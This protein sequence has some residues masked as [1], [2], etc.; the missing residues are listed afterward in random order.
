M[1]S[2]IYQNRVC[3]VIHSS[4]HW[5]HPSSVPNQWPYSNELP[6]KSGRSEESKLSRLLIKPTKSVSWN[7]LKSQKIVYLK[8]QIGKQIMTLFLEDSIKKRS[9]YDHGKCKAEMK[10]SILKP[11]SSSIIITWRMCR[12]GLSTTESNRIWDWSLRKHS[13]SRT[14]FWRLSREIFIKIFLKTQKYPDMKKTTY[15]LILL[16]ILIERCSRSHREFSKLL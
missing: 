13:I 2:K 11:R 3:L 12:K 10:T 5:R 8:Q 4:T 6:V 14:L 16:V 9:K 15:C 1:Y 7:R